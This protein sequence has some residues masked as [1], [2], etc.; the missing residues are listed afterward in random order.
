MKS[1]DYNLERNEPLHPKTKPEAV[2]V[3][4]CVLTFNRSSLLRE[5]LISLRG[6]K[7]RP[8]EIVVVDNHSEDGT[9]AMMQEQFHD[10][11]H[12][13]TNKNIGADARNLGLRRATGDFVITL[14]DDIFGIEDKDILCLVDY[15]ARR[16]LLG[17]IN[18][19]VLDGESDEICNWVHHCKPEECSEKEFLT[20][21]ITEGAVAFRKSALQMSGYYPDNFFLS[22]EGP[23][24]ALRMLNKGLEVI[25]SPMIRVLHRHSKLGRKNWLNYYYD[26]R[27][28][29]WLA[30]RNFPL[31]YALRYLFRGLSSMLIYSLRDGYLL[32]WM[33]GVVEGILGLGSVWETRNP[34]NKRTMLLIKAIDQKRPPL[35]YL[36]RERLLKKGVRL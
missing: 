25:Y 5:L 34:I 26:T 36:F 8:L 22:H 9:Q 15:F 19:K 30:A 29:L 2:P 3:S 28:L 35:I 32:Y 24:L 10:I 6:L 14:D 27:N 16:P 12:I 4:I 33:K 1:L 7:Y 18:F 31:S 13:R 23:D 20:Y 17:A 21:E 11:L